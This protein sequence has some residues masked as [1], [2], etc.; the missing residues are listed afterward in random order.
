MSLM[1][2]KGSRKASFFL[3]NK[4]SEYSDGAR[5][6]KFSENYEYEKRVDIYIIV[7]YHIIT[8]RGKKND[9]KKE[10]K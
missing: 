2:I 8:E 3:E 4:L 10:T 6:D 9:K 5:A 1:E 7:C